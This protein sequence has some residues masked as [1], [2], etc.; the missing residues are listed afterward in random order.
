MWQRHNTGERGGRA[1]ARRHGS[2]HK[3]S[4]RTGKNKR[5]LARS[6]DT[7]TH[8]QTIHRPPSP[9]LHVQGGLA[10]VA[11]T[12][13][14]GPNARLG[15]VARAGHQTPGPGHEEAPGR[16]PE[17][18]RVVH[19]ELAAPVVPGVLRQVADEEPGDGHGLRAVARAG[20][21]VGA[22][23]TQLVVPAVEAAGGT[24]GGTSWAC[25]HHQ[26]TH[27]TLFPPP[28]THTQRPMHAH[29]IHGN[30][31]SP[32]FPPP[33]HVCPLGC[34]LHAP[35]ML[36]PGG[37]PSPPLHLRPHTLPRVRNTL[38]CGT[39]AC[40]THTRVRRHTHSRAA[41]SHAQR[42]QAPTGMPR[43]PRHTGTGAW[44]STRRT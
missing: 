44:R 20:G 31:N 16:R 11:H 4:P 32:P 18:G 1:C 3:T 21:A 27:L 5:V 35:E 2:Q 34:P 39:L 29:Y 43:T 40:G 38:A 12:T 6:P 7:C 24:T 41:H 28:P 36:A 25:E 33:P 13:L 19:V 9:T 17:H 37:A 30:S 23:G 42:Q 8:T 14:V 22:G 15:R 10:D 26:C